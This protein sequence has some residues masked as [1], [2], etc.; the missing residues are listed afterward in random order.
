MNDWEIIKQ[1]GISKLRAVLDGNVVFTEALFTY[2]QYA[3][4]YDKA[5]SICQDFSKVNGLYEA[6]QSEFNDFIDT[7][8]LPRLKQC[9]SLEDFMDAWKCYLLYVKWM[10]AFFSYMERNF[11]KFDFHRYYIDVF[12]S[13]CLDDFYIFHFFMDMVQKKR[14]GEL[15]DECRMIEI[16]NI[17][18]YLDCYEKLLEKPFLI[19]SEVYY[20]QPRSFIDIIRVM[21]EEVKFAETYLEPSTVTLVQKQCLQMMIIDNVDGIVGVV[22][23]FV[24]QR[25]F[26][27]MRSFIRIFNMLPPKCI[28][29]AVALVEAEFNKDW[30]LLYEQHKELSAAKIEA[31]YAL[32]DVYRRLTVGNRPLHMAFKRRIEYDLNADEN[33]CDVLSTYADTVLKGSGIDAD[34]CSSTLVRMLSYLHDKDIFEK[35]YRFRLMKR[36]LTGKFASFDHE[37]MFVSKMKMEFSASYAAQMEGMLSDFLISNEIKKTFT[38]PT[39]I[40]FSVQVLNTSHW[41]TVTVVPLELPPLMGQCFDAFQSFY[42]SKF[43]K[44][45]LTLIHSLD[46]CVVSAKFAS[47]VDLSMTSLQAIVLLCFNHAE[48]LPV[49]G[50]R[51][52]L[53]N[54]DVEVLKRVLHSLTRAKVLL[55]NS[56]LDKVAIEDTVSVNTAF[57]SNNRRLNVPMSNIEEIARSKDVEIDRTSCIEATIVRVMKARKQLKHNELCIEVVKQINIFKPLP[58]VIKGC[59]ESLIDRAYLERSEE[60]HNLYNYVA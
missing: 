34:V 57:K 10:R 43:S 11:T 52:M 58:K 13:K 51:A 35:M 37:K 19:Q 30:V 59:I 45:M 27:N 41:P 60:D 3:L 18:K 6:Q 39:P 53:G 38:E 46:V 9:S 42:A 7:S 44:R 14:R 24:R 33:I 32:D 54:M 36:L 1:Q 48:S 15:V 21:D 49:S 4:V 8:L 25:D 47:K 56:G 23:Q 12:T 16:V 29:P 40:D 17:C 31:M 22:T 26:D 2:K 50:I 20:K 28:E 55:N 5:Y